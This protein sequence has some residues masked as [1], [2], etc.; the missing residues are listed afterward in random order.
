MTSASRTCSKCGAKLL[1]DAPQ[2]F[3]SACL[4]E[5]ALQDAAEELPGE[6]PRG[7][8]HGPGRGGLKDFGNYGLLEELGRGAQ[9]VV[10]RARQKDLDRIVAL[11]V[12][13]LGSWATQA[14]LKRFRLEAAAAARLEHPQIVPIYEVGERDGCC[15]FSMRLV[16]GGRLDQLLAR[17]PLPGRRT[18]E[19]LASLARTVHFAHQHGLLHRDIKPANVLL[20][21]QGLPHLT[22]FGL[23]KLV[24]QQSTLTRTIDVMGTPAYMSPEQ[25]AGD[26]RAL[27][28]STDVYGLGAV[29]YHMLTGSPPFAGGTTY[30]TIRLVQETE[31]RLPKLL[32]PAADRELQTIC[33]KCLR[34]EPA[35]RYGS[36]ETL[37]EDLERWLRGEPIHAR[38]VGTPERV[39]RWCRRKPALAGALAAC[40]V[41][42]LALA[43]GSTIAAL[44]IQRARELAS[45]A[46]TKAKAELYSAYLAQARAQR[47]SGVAGRKPE[48]LRAVTAATR[49]H[50]SVELRNEAIAALALTDIGAPEQWLGAD[51]TLHF[52]TVAL[53]PKF[54]RCA[55]YAQRGDTT[56]RRRSDGKVLARL[57]TPPTGDARLGFSESG[58]FFS[59][60]WSAGHL[61]VWDLLNS[62]PTLCTNFPP[63]PDGPHSAAFAPDER[64]L[65]VADLQ[66]AIHLCDPVTGQ[67]SRLLPTGG[68]IYRLDYS[69]SGGLLAC[70]V[71]N[72]IHLWDTTRGQRR[73]ALQH[74]TNAT[75]VEWHP[76]GR[77]LAA[78]YDNGN[79]LLWD[80]QTGQGNPLA[81]HVQYINGAVFDP[82]GQFLVTDSWDGTTRFWDVL[83][84]RQLCW[85][86]YAA[87]EQ[88]SQDGRFISFWRVRGSLG[89]WPVLR[90]PVFRLVSTVAAAAPSGS[91]CLS[92]DGRWLVF[93]ESGAW[94]LWDTGLAKE[95]VSLPAQ[96]TTYP[97]FKRDGH[98]LIASGPDAVLRWPLEASGEWGAA[99][100]V[101]A[102]E[103]LLTVPGAEFQRLC[104]SADEATLAIVGHRQSLLV[105]L[106]NPHNQIAFAQGQRNSFVTFSSDG[107]WV[108]AASYYGLGVT[109]W[110]ARD[111][112]LAHRLITNENAT[113]SFS[114]DSRTLVTATTRECV[115]WDT[116][117][118]EPRYRRPLDLGGEVPAV[119]AFSPQGGLLALIAAKDQV[120][121]LEPYTGRRLAVLTSPEPDTLGWLAF[122][123]EGR[124]L[125]AQTTAKYVHLWDLAAL[126]RELAALNLD[127]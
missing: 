5:S 72:E 4:L 49:L 97:V 102:P 37:A 84:R 101:G 21:A 115:W 26:T 118:W 27:S 50:P 15:Y 12:V 52:D 53:D 34:K 55:L 127:W 122:S 87:A 70:V 91:A 35:G 63:V 19:L 89:I 82:L 41:L 23:A 43:S 76:D 11:K 114:P 109:V 83:T 39:W 54:E 81:G 113:V 31:P 25:A 33:L 10:Y 123:G 112:R 124:Y 18:A 104:L 86:S 93:G 22:D 94:H 121:L 90:S 3:C 88:A 77:F 47:L 1:P 60:Q 107:R 45:V 16:E 105:E 119:A 95:V 108:A 46:E 64:T 66:G 68:P 30:E 106:A 2:Q 13:A 65:A 92:A 40:L 38:Q 6:P 20:D 71:N 7:V 9:G 78:G 79:V 69:P 8:S 36:A 111:G 14:H 17:G 126:H 110:D 29:L 99:V 96:G 85:T 24:E 58:R 56:I 100:R 74:K 51:P 67:E 98:S 59:V 120:E 125:A 57:S 73:R 103:I 75:V 62:P 116:Q 117:S 44:R 80:T 32:N 42:L 48:C 61:W 28:T